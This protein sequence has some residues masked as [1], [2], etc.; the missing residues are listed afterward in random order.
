MTKEERVCQFYKLSIRK[1]G[2]IFPCC[3][4]IGSSYIGNLFEED[5]IKKIATKNVECECT[6][7]KNRP[8][9]ENEKPNVQRIHIEFSNECQAKCICCNQQKEKMENEDIH[10]QKL[11]ELIKNYKPKYITVIG[12]EVLIQ[13]KSLDWIEKIK[14]KYPDIS[15]DIVTNLCVGENTIKRAIKI[16]DDITVSI[17]GFSQ[18][19]YNRIMGLDFDKTI[20]NVEYILANSNVKIRPKYLLMPTNMYEIGSFLKWALKLNTQKIYLH[21]IREFRQCCNLEDAYWNN[22]F[23]QI[24]TEL[25]EILIQ[26]KDLIISK[27]RH[28]ISI[29]DIL[30]E[31]TNMNTFIQEQGFENIIKITS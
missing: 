19:T 21:N 29:H 5:I 7:Y 2:N 15:F 30:A 14:N 22:T 6:L 3:L 12:G 18:N 4:A 28:F 8:I 1:N 10:L 20:K 23:N 24:E 31:K 17:L 11:D 16:F 13:K 27:N 9:K 26:N 25:K